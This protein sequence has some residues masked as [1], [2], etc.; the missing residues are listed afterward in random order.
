VSDLGITGTRVVVDPRC[1]DRVG[2]S[3]P[4]SNG[5]VCYSE[6][7]AMSEAIYICNDDFT[8]MGDATRVCQNDGNWNGS[9]PRCIP[10][11][12]AS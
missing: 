11:I 6:T 9:T 12:V 3:L 8:L 5:V 7:T 2:N 1:P 10:G 4:I